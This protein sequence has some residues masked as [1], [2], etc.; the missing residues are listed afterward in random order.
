MAIH[1]ENLEIVTVRLS[2]LTFVILAGVPGNIVSVYLNVKSFSRNK[3]N[4]IVYLHLAIVDLCL[5]FLHASIGLVLESVGYY[6]LNND[7]GSWGPFLEF[8][9]QDIGLRLY[10]SATFVSLTALAFVALLRTWRVFFPFGQARKKILISVFVVSDLVIICFTG[11]LSM[12]Q[13][14][15]S[16]PTGLNSNHSGNHTDD[17]DTQNDTTN[18]TAVINESFIED[19][20]DIGSPGVTQ[21]NDFNFSA[22]VLTWACGIVVILITTAYILICVK[23]KVEFQKMATKDDSQAICFLRRQLKHLI[24]HFILFGVLIASSMPSL[25]SSVLTN[26]SMALTRLMTTTGLLNSAVN[27]YIYC[28]LVP[29]YRRDITRLLCCKNSRSN[30]SSARRSR[31]SKNSETLSSEIRSGQ[32]TRSTRSTKTQSKGIANIGF[33]IG[34]KDENKGSDDA[35][36]NGTPQPEPLSV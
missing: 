16:K 33:I 3:L 26:K 10:F 8:L 34:K 18:M 13:R 27:P 17:L 1:Y 22:T 4:G 5:C 20:E 31:R 36:W 28:L 7:M 15:L 12:P 24:T 2:L 30:S 21:I 32:S 6:S 19:T 25:M 35:Q 29:A 14:Y 9:A 23:L 11:L